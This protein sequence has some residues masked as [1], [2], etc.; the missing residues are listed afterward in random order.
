MN[1]E[2][3]G[4]NEEVQ[5][6]NEIG[7]EWQVIFSNEVELSNGEKKVIYEE[8]MNK[9]TRETRITHH[10]LECGHQGG[11][12]TQ[13]QICDRNHI[14]DQSCF[15]NIRICPHGRRFC[16]NAGCGKRYFSKEPKYWSFWCFTGVMLVCFIKALLK[17]IW[18]L[19]KGI[20]KVIWSIVSGIFKAI[21]RKWKVENEQKQQGIR[22]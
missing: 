15:G 12:E 1:D 9:V 13:V 8:K 2:I 19:I 20:F 6:P 22:F 21:A 14:H 7:D 17:G 18:W 4:I 16:T 5:T 3:Q 10:L 11:R